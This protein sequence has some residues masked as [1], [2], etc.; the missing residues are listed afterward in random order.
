MGFLEG[1]EMNLIE[2]IQKEIDRRQELLKIYK[3]IPPE[4]FSYMMIVLDIERGEKAII[5]GDI[6][7][8]IKV[9]KALRGCK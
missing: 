8:M 7:E 9:Y 2:G 5:S 4:K 3:K 6:V 1:K